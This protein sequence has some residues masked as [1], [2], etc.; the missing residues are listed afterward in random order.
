MK[1]QVK[2]NISLGIIPSIVSKSDVN[3]F[4]ILPVGTVSKNFIGPL[5][6]LSN[7]FLWIFFEALT[8]LIGSERKSNVYLSVQYN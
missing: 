3:L 1:H 2:S 7:K 6:I 5:I 8:H 4:K